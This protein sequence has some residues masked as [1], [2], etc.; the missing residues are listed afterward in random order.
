MSYSV[1]INKKLKIKL[2]KMSEALDKTVS[3]LIS[4]ILEYATIEFNNGFAYNDIVK[5]G[6][7]KEIMFKISGSTYKKLETLTNK[8]HSTRNSTIIDL[9]ENAFNEY[10]IEKCKK[11]K[12]ECICPKNKNISQHDIESKEAIA[13]FLQNIKIKKEDNGATVV[14]TDKQSES[15]EFINGGILFANMVLSLESYLMLYKLGEKN[16]LSPWEMMDKIIK[17]EVLRDNG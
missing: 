1:Y 10:F 9:I 3:N 6:E 13:Q 7:L 15:E 4:E 2:D 8:N 5:L 14:Y 11:S 16:N 12:P 17:N